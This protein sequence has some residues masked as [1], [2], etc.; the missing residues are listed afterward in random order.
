MERVEVERHPPRSRQYSQRPR[1]ASRKGSYEIPR[2]PLRPAK[3]R[4]TVVRETIHRRSPSV[5]YRYTDAEPKA[6]VIEEKVETYPRKVP[7]HFYD[8]LLHEQRPSSRDNHR[9]HGTRERASSGKQYSVEEVET[10]S[11]CP[12]SKDHYQEQVIHERGQQERKYIIEEVETV[13]RRA[14]S[15]D[16]YE[17][18][19]VVREPPMR[20]YHEEREITLSSR[21]EEA[22]RRRRRE[23]NTPSSVAPPWEAP[24]DIQPTGNEDLIVVT[25]RYEYRPKRQGNTEEDRRRQEFVDRVTLDRQQ[26]YQISMEDAAKYYHED[27]SRAEPEY[28][29]EPLRKMEHHEPAGYRRNRYQDLELSDSEASYEYRT[30]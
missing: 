1:S 26:A 13:S 24:H 6:T 29:R 14:S 27:W 19:G 8:D 3:V 11:R 20:E 10:V 17:E 7:I 25:E 22:R 5:E 28:S 30:G 4:E 23:R 2:K 9:E 18:R 15:R 12:S 21:G 16:Y